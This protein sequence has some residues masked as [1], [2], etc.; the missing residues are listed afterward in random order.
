MN[1]VCLFPQQLEG[2]C[3]H[4]LKLGEEKKN[5]LLVAE[6]QDA[7]EDSSLFQVKLMAPGLSRSK[8]RAF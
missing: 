2:D 1:V 5:H 8:V 4:F 7:A 6:V 3:D